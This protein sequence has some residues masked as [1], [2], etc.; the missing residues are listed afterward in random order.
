[1]SENT[2]TYDLLR[3]LEAVLPVVVL[4]APFAASNW[5]DAGAGIQAVNRDAITEN[6]MLLLEDVARAAERA[7]DTLE[8]EGA[9]PG[10]CLTFDGELLWDTVSTLRPLCWTARLL[11]RVYFGGDTES[12]EGAAEVMDDHASQ[13]R[14]LFERLSEVWYGPRAE[15]KEA[16]DAS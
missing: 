7:L 10:T 11:A 4:T 14:R 5:P 6:G 15:T 1:M 13:M 8:N 9:R 12:I 2:P 3:V 16:A